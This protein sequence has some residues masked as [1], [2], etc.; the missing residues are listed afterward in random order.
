MLTWEISSQT[1]RENVKGFESRRME[2]WGQ[3]D[4]IAM[5][6]NLTWLRDI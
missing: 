2:A 3:I 4:T 5:P 1:P 6:G